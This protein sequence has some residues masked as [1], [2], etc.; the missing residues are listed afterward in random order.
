MRGVSSFSGFCLVF[1]LDFFNLAAYVFSYL[2]SIETDVLRITLFLVYCCYFLFVTMATFEQEI[3][4]ERG[5]AGRPSFSSQK[6]TDRLRECERRPSVQANTKKKLQKQS[7]FREEGLD[8]LSTSV[9]RDPHDNP[10]ET[11]TIPPATI[12]KEDSNEKKRKFEEPLKEIGQKSN[13][14]EREKKGGW[15][16]KLAKGQRPMV[17]NSATASPGS[18]TSIP[19]VALIVFLI[20]IVVP[21]LR[22]KGDTEV[23][24]NGADAGVIREAELVDNASAIEGR[25][26]SPT[27]VCTRWA[28]QGMHHCFKELQICSLITKLTIRSCEC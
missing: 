5:R 27:S 22:S 18:F 12:K 24:M 13:V 10:N 21:G 11:A 9:Y 26:N 23:N 15:Y 19:R 25:A 2:I 6:T 1:T 7:V 14:N 20:A 28:Q 16:S 8:D 3:R 4:P 17:K